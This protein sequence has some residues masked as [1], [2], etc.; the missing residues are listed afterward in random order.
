MTAEISEEQKIYSQ[1]VADTVQRIQ[2]YERRVR[3][4]GLDDEKDH[5]VRAS[6]REQLS[7]DILL[8][9][10]ELQM[11]MTGAR[12]AIDFFQNTMPRMNVADSFLTAEDFAR[13]NKAEADLSRIGTPPGG[14]S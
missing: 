2:S 11:A 4:T 7:N 6:E 1:L 5:V 13:W 8:L 9:F 3:P 10:Y 12:S 14:F